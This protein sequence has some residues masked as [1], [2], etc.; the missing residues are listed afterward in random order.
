MNS[1]IHLSPSFI[2]AGLLAMMTSG[3]SSVTGGRSIK[4]G[5]IAFVT[6]GTTTGR[7][8]IENLGPPLLEL[9]GGHLLAYSWETS[10][11]LRVTFHTL[12]RETGEAGPKP[13]QWVFC[14]ATDRFFR[15]FRHDTITAAENESVQNAALAWYRELGPPTAQAH[16]GGP[17]LFR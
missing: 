13:K 9:E 6:A 12:G 11:H 17:P 16:R 2:L 8:V 5:A 1:L 4:P 10:S 14:V 7:E 15:V 3:C